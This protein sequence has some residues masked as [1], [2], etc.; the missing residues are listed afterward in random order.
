MSGDLFTDTFLSRQQIDMVP[1]FFTLLVYSFA[2]LILKYSR[3]DFGST[4]KLY[5]GKDASKSAQPSAHQT[6]SG[7]TQAKM[8]PSERAQPSAH[9]MAPG[10]TSCK[11]CKCR[12][13]AEPASAELLSLFFKA[14][15]NRLSFN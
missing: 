9:Q 12:W 1:F 7:E 5:T 11:S 15:D 10:K 8:L 14:Q 13:R 6:A 3:V 2:S 4:Q